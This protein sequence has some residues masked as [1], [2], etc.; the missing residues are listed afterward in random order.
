V[1]DA[2]V[3]ALHMAAGQSCVQVFFFR[4]GRNNGNRPYFLTHA[5]ADISPEEVMAGFLAQL[6]D[7]LPPPPL[8]LLSHD[9][10]EAA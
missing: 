9:V 4:G 5:R 2:D 1:G 3:I 7:D 10:P 8:V 6:Y